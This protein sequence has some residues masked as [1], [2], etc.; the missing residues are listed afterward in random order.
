[1][2]CGSGTWRC[3]ACVQEGRWG[4]SH[5]IES[6]VTFGDARCA[7][8]SATYSVLV[9]FH[10]EGIAPEPRYLHGRPPPG[11]DGTSEIQDPALYQDLCACQ[12]RR[13]CKGQDPHGKLRRLLLRP[14]L[15]GP[16]WFR[17][18]MT[19]EQH[20]QTFQ[21]F[22]Q[23]PPQSTRD[24]A[25]RRRLTDPSSEVYQS[26]LRRD[27]QSWLLEEPC[28]RPDLVV[29]PYDMSM[30]GLYH[31]PAQGWDRRCEDAAVR[32]LRGASAGPA[33][34]GRRASRRRPAAD[35][36][37]LA[38]RVATELTHLRDGV[39]QGAYLL[40]DGLPV[41]S[42]GKDALFT[43]TRAHL[44]RPCIADA[45]EL[46]GRLTEAAGVDA[47]A[48]RRSEPALVR[49]LDRLAAS[50]QDEVAASRGYW[51]GLRA[52]L[53]ARRASRPAHVRFFFLNCSV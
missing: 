16:A 46:L 22:L 45:R 40:Y 32:R 25:H 30:Q 31:L 50:V 20:A 34:R 47:T 49:R 35:Q 10:A 37:M 28:L 11:C 53:A 43:A 5:L 1:M 51:E 13:L 42:L 9:R 17:P 18:D 12:Q 29:T 36:L 3:G 15:T 7:K 26:A 4:V 21:A 14:P 41:H 38:E 19:A 8:G 24:W 44:A 39:I 33:P 23:R 52:A 48:L 27:R 6:A 2:G